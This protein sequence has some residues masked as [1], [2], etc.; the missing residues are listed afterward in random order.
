MSTK[1]EAK[2]QKADLLAQYRPLGLKAVLAASM[3]LKKTP[4][5]KLA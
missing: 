3:M 4:K 5:K 1:T 2:P